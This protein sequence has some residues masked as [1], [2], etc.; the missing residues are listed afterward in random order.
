VSTDVSEI[1]LD[2]RDLRKTV[3]ARFDK[4]DARFEKVDARFDKLEEKVN[5]NFTQLIEKIG[6][7]KVWTLTVVATGILAVVARAFHW[8]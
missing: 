7:L 8:L 1:K 5:E 4:V 2:V 3:D 6:D